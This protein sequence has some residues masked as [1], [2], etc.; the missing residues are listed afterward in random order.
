MKKLLLFMAA[1]LMMTTAQA[2]DQNIEG[3]IDGFSNRYRWM[4]PV[5]FSMNQADFYVYPDGHIEFDLRRNNQIYHYSRRAVDRRRGLRGRQV[6]YNRQG[7]P[8]RVN[9][10]QIFYDRRGRVTQ[11]GRVDVGYHRG[12]LDYVGGLDVRYHRNGQL[13]AARGQVKFWKNYGRNDRRFRNFGKID[14][15]HYNDVAYN[16]RGRGNNK[17]K[18]KD[19]KRRR[20]F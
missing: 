13:L 14:K 4:E 3:P 9:N 1:G 15:R 7:L 16:D 12:T 18:V 6:R 17:Y 2:T 19:K 10:T 8:I 20:D 5:T 11:I